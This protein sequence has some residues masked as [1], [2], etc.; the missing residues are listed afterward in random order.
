MK[1]RI[2]TLSNR[3]IKKSFKRFISLLVMS[4]LGVG[5]FIGLN[6]TSDSMIL[7]LDKYY[8]NNNVYDIKIVSL[9]GLT[10]DD[11]N[12]IKNIDNNNEVYGYNYQDVL[13]D[14]IH[15]GGEIE[16]LAIVNPSE[17]VTV[18]RKD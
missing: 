3:E 1:D 14:N 7:S 13:L 2:I 12:F 5:V 9:L 11:V 17:A 6:I 18:V 10:D 4:L 8:E 16:A 15:K